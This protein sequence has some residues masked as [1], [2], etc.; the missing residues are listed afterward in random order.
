MV[1]HILMSTEGVTMSDTETPEAPE[2]TMSNSKKEM[3]EIYQQMR[4][5]ILAQEDQL[6][7]ADK[8]RQRLEAE[9]AQVAA[10]ALRAEEPLQRIFSL[11]SELGR[12]LNELAEGF[13]KEMETYRQLQTAVELK[14]QELNRIYGIEGAAIDLEILLKAQQ[15]R[16]ADFEEKRAAQ[17]VAFEMQK[18]REREEWEQEKLEWKLQLKETSER[19]AR[20][21]ERDEEEYT[22]A[23]NREREQMRDSMHDEMQAL[24]QEIASKR[25]RLDEM[26]EHRTMELDRR[27]L[28]LS[29]QEAE[30]HE[31]REKMAAVPAQ[32][33]AAVTEETKK[34]EQ[35]LK[36]DYQAREA[37]IKESFQSEKSLLLNKLEALEEALE[38]KQEQLTELTRKQQITFDAMQDITRKVVDASCREFA[39]LTTE[40]MEYA[41]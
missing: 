1:Y 14:R 10:E 28:E 24:E 30:L 38:I 13:E 4:Q 22:Y 5:Q 35:R 6:A 34:I 8:V 36:E 3:L 25:A 31:L 19:I 16:K 32:F 15:S 18:M 7:D 20:E 39:S 33:K 40:S 12:R 41:D 27:E 2:M 9:A 37:L 17:E 23:I 29:E 21:R 26:A 11:R